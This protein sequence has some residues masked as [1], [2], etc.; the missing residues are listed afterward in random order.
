[1]QPANLRRLVIAFW[2]TAAG[3]LLSGCAK[4][5]LIC[6]RVVHAP[7]PPMPQQHPA[8]VLFATD[9][10]PESRDLLLFSADL[11]PSGTH[12]SYGAKC[13]DPTGE[14][15]ECGAPPRW[16]E[17]GEFFERIRASPGDVLLFVHGFNYSFDESLDIALRIVERTRF[18]ATPVAYSWPSQGK[19]SAYGLDYDMSEWTIDHLTG[20]I[21]ELIAALPEG[22]R[23]HIVA[24]S[25]GNRAV[26]LALARLDLPQ[27]R[28][29]QLVLIAPDVE[30]QI[31][32]ELVLHTG[33][34]QRRTLYVSKRDLALRASAML[35]RSGTTRA[36]DADKAY[37]V[38]KDLDTIDMSPLKAGVLGHSIYDYPQ[39][40]FDDLGSVL[41]DQ[42]VANRNLTACTVKSIAQANAEH[43]TSLP[44]QVYVLPTESNHPSASAAK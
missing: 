3:V 44:C 17:H 28:L 25:M 14:K 11:N 40:M 32:K 36:G 29:G 15:A 43:G 35:L 13:V 21:R 9:R 12:L 37:V 31:F 39:L 7:D 4:Q 20:F 2:L 19:V 24:H 23:L 1:M 5:L 18:T 16:L 30:S 33:P 8:V 41:R 22:S 10:L 27:Q 38:I 6:P 42:S 34:F 26:L